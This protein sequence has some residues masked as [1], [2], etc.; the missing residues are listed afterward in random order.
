MPFPCQLLSLSLLLFLQRPFFLKQETVISTG[1]TDN[2]I[3]RR[4]VDCSHSSQLQRTDSCCGIRQ[5]PRILP[6]HL[7]WSL[8]EVVTPSS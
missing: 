2:T 8:S 5:D 7:R 3:V 4:A 6:L 1:A